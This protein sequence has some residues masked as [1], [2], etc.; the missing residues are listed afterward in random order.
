[1][2]V[3]NLWVTQLFSRKNGGGNMEKKEQ[4]YIE[5]DNESEQGHEDTR[6]KNFEC[7]SPD[8][9]LGCD[10]GIDVAG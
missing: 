10:P 5:S 9:H 8:S 6:W 7:D 1:M 2:I 4:D 3:M